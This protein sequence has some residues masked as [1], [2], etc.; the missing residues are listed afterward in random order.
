[1]AL[2]FQF[3]QSA[4]GFIET[5]IFNGIVVHLDRLSCGSRRQSVP[6]GA[7]NTGQFYISSCCQTSCFH[8]L[9]KDGPCRFAETY[10]FLCA[11]ILQKRPLRIG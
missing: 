10:S 1:M 7:G 4:R 9:V 8:C 11:D 3:A 5:F 2:L 6:P